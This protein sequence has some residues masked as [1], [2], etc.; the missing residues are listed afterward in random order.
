MEPDQVGADVAA[1]V[2]PQLADPL[3]QLRDHEV[4]AVELLRLEREVGAFP[5]EIRGEHPGLQTRVLGHLGERLP[6]EVFLG[7]IGLRAPARGGRG[8]TR[9]D[10][11]DGAGQRAEQQ[12]QRERAVR[13][14]GV[15][16]GRLPARDVASPYSC[17]VESRQVAP[18]A[19]CWAVGGCPNRNYATILE[20][21][22][23]TF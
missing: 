3:G 14:D 10:H 8:R 7:A 17:R 5:F 1:A 22:L 18:P 9:L 16:G 19:G 11:A 12:D 13:A 23:A 15:H 4:V 20:V 21:Y 6:G 2:D